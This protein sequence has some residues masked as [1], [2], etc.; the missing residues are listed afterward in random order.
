MKTTTVT[1]IQAALYCLFSFLVN[2][3]LYADFECRPLRSRDSLFD[4]TDSLSFTD[5]TDSPVISLTDSIEVVSALTGRD[6][7]STDTSL[8]GQ[9]AQ[10][11]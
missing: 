2:D 9:L 4:L 11:K 8:Y 10:L 1:R 3:C 5:S 7:C 6:C